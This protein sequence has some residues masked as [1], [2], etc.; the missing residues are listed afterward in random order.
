MTRSLPPQ[1]IKV[2]SPQPGPSSPPNSMTDDDLD[3]PLPNDDLDS[4]GLD[5]LPNDD[6]DLPLED[7]PLPSDDLVP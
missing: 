4:R 1:C 3:S 7:Q 5:E 6:L 2:D